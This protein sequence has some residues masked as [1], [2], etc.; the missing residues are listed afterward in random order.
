MDISN[1]SPQTVFGYFGEIC[2]IPHGSGNTGMLE[3]Y[4]IDFAVKHGLDYYHDA[5]GNVMI[6]KDGTPGYENSEPVIL[7]AHL[8]MVC[9]KTDECT[10]DM[11]K[12]GLKVCSDGEYIWADGTTLGADDGIA[13]AY[14]LAVLSSKDAAHPPVEALFTVDEEIGMIGA[15]GLDASR[16]KGRRLINI[17]SEKEGVLTTSCAGGI[18]VK[19]EVP[20]TYENITSPR[21]ARLSISGLKGGHSGIDIGKGHVNAI[22][23]LGRLMEYVSR[24]CEIRITKLSGG[25]K[26]NAIA[27]NAYADI[28]FEPGCA[29]TIFQAVH[30][31]FEIA[32]NEFHLSEPE[33]SISIVNTEESLLC[34][35]IESTRKIIFALMQIADGIQAMSPDIPDMVQ[36]SMNLGTVFTDNRLL[37]MK[38]LIRSNAAAGKQKCVEKLVSFI[39]YFDGRLEFTSDYPAWEYRMS[40]PLRDIMVKTYEEVYADSPEIFSIHAGLE[41]GILASKLPGVDMISFGPDMESVHTPCER[42]NAASAGRSF[43]YLLKVL[44]NLK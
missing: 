9:D 23:L 5:V 35:D 14:I 36:T 32:H 24:R 41:C 22:R 27:K 37:T 26:E 43:L 42:L 21:F 3:N 13:V 15:N 2:R 18:R 19:C 20:I 34:T 33:L 16:L 28:C 11:E 4:C 12:E 38:Y 40:S 1:L 8:D 44:E 6:F 29:D 31:F 10:I 39:E 17:D 7:Q 30:S 25:G